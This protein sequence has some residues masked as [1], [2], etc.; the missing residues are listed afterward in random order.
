[1]TDRDLYPALGT[2]PPEVVEVFRSFWR[3]AC[4]ERSFVLHAVGIP[5]Q[6]AWLGRAWALLVPVESLPAAL[7]HLEQY[8]H[9][10]PPRRSRCMAAR[11]WGRLPMRP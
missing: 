10:N 11:G 3:N 6:V 7:A 2:P 1:M 8:A 9:E 5:S 4:E